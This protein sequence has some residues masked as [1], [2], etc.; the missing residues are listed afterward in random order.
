MPTKPTAGPW[1]ARKDEFSHYVTEG[2][3]RNRIVHAVYGATPAES[4]A[5]TRL[6]AAAPELYQDALAIRDGFIY[7]PGHSDLDD[8][9]PISVRMSLGDYRRVLQHIAKAEG[10]G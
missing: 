5:R 2:D 3:S 1:E 8:E 9:Q 7:D 4:E 6:I 10:N